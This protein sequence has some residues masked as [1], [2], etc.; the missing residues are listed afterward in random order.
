MH[1]Y[2]C[3]YADAAAVLARVRSLA[4]RWLKLGESLRSACGVADDR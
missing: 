3:P 4:S 2:H 1:A